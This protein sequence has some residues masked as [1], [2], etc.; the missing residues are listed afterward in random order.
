[1][2]MR[3]PHGG[4]QSAKVRAAL[5]YARKRRLARLS[6][7]EGG[8]AYS[9]NLYTGYIHL[10]GGADLDASSKIEFSCWV[11]MTHPGSEQQWLWSDGNDTQI[12]LETDGTLRVK[13]EATGSILYH[14]RTH[15]AVQDG[16]LS[17]IYVSYDGATGTPEIIIDGVTDDLTTGLVFTA[18]SAGTIHAGAI[19]LLALNGAFR[20]FE[21]QFG[22]LWVNNPATFDGHAAFWNGGTPP[23][24]SGLTQPVIWLG[25]SQV[26]AD[27]A[28]GGNNGT[29][30]LTPRAGAALTDV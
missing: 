2:V 16:V 3:S 12:M 10:E 8:G 26:A 14:Y 9:Q 13:F 24:L 15:L 7:S 4:L 18:A 6:G 23:D 20:D 5:Y 17:H 11:N 22:D 28:A 29:A 25:G 19:D 30:T 21:G 27:I 1:M